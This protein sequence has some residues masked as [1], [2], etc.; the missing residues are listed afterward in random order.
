M[1]TSEIVNKLKKYAEFIPVC[2]EVEIG[3]GIPRRPVRI[4]MSSGKQKLVQPAY[5]TDLTSDMI[6]F[7]N[8]FLDKIGQ[9]DGFI[10]KSKS[11][12]CGIGDVKLY[13]KVES[14]PVVGKGNGMFGEAVKTKYSHLAIEDDA[15]LLNPKV[16]EHFLT[17][18]FTLAR[19][20]VLEKEGKIKALMDFHSD[21]KYLL[22]AYNQAEMRNL[23][24]IIGTQKGWAFEEVYH[25]YGSHLR[26]AFAKG[27]KFSSYINILHHTFGYVS[28][29]LSKEEKEFFLDMVEM[30]REDRTPLFTCLALIRS[31]VVRF[32][33]EYLANQTIFE[34]YPQDL[35][36]TFDANR[37]RN[38]WK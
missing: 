20:R 9:V 23:G 18:L 3:L 26:S 10:L 32:D 30:Y 4:V 34:P 6:Q 7:T 25:D 5:A 2:P 27:P 14:S 35:G 12:S 11:P 36:A 15:R 17:K 33:V 29:K 31:W 1:I 24:K 37:W 21:N 8:S 19:F 16:K 28:K 13:S 22:M 38:Y